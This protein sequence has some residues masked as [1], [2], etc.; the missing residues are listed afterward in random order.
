MHTLASLITGLVWSIAALLPA[1]SPAE[2]TNLL[3]VARRWL[4][5]VGRAVWPE[6]R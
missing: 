5:R 2:L 6:V 3:A 4:A 1:L